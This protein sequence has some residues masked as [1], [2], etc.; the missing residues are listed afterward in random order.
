MSPWA[1]QISSFGIFQE[2]DEEL[3]RREKQIGAREALVQQELQQREQA[4][5]GQLKEMEDAAAARVKEA[6][7]QVSSFHLLSSAC[8]CLDVNI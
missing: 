6:E 1:A 8:C 4:L 3:A 7:E 5:D 2:R